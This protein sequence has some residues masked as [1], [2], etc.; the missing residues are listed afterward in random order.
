MRESTTKLGIAIKTARKSR[1]LTQME[2]SEE[3]GITPRHLQAIENENKT[4]S[5]DLLSRIL[6]Y[7][8]IPAD[9]ILSAN[10]SD[11]TPEQEQLL[12]LIKHKCDHRDVSVLLS[13]AEALVNTKNT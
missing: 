6:S 13:T 5:Y 8:N 10:E 1:N 3:L 7:L 12:Y 9:S 2:L 4:P 11:L